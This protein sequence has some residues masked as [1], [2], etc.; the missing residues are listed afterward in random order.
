MCRTRLRLVPLAARVMDCHYLETRRIK[1]G[2]M[3]LWLENNSFHLWDSLR[4]ESELWFLKI[5]FPWVPFAFYF[6]IMCV[7]RYKKLKQAWSFRY[8]ETKKYV[9]THRTLIEALTLFVVQIWIKYNGRCFLSA[10]NTPFNVPSHPRHCK[11]PTHLTNSLSLSR[12]TFVW[13]INF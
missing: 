3:S 11:N 12:K 7:S 10:E 4:N 1:A 13:F 2:F 5:I 9:A 6:F 8:I